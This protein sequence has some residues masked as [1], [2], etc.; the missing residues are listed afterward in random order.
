MPVATLTRPHFQRFLKAEELK[1]AQIVTGTLECREVNADN[2]E[3][4]L[5]ISSFRKDDYGTR[6]DPSGMDL[7][8]Y[9]RNPLVSFGHM[10]DGGIYRLPVARG[11]PDSITIDDD[12]RIHMR[13]R[14]TPEDVFEFG[15][16]VYKLVRN[17]F[18]NGVS[19]AA[20]PDPNATEVVREA[21]G[22]STLVFRKWKLYDASIVP[23]PSND[24]ALV[25]ARCKKFKV[26]KASYRELERLLDD[27][28]EVTQEEVND[29]AGELQ[30]TSP[31]E[32]GQQGTA[33]EGAALASPPPEAP[34]EQIQDVQA[35]LS[36]ARAL[37]LKITISGKVH[38]VSRSL[39]IPETEDQVKHREYFEENKDILGLYRKLLE[40]LYR[41]IGERASGQEKS[42][43]ERILSLILSP[44]SSSS[45]PV[46]TATVE[47]RQ[48]SASEAS[49]LVAK[50]ATG[51]ASQLEQDLHSGMPIRKLDARMKELIQGALK[52]SISFPR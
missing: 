18:L 8:Q 20:Q 27:E 11:I 33:P 13:A 10:R 25:A 15:F 35:E 34:P 38:E 4:E 23:L 31:E 2:L 29:V 7:S 42:D 5:I 47:T 6:F 22:T 37:H 41:R 43:V 28:N 44:L 46:R 3:V 12:G 36:P 49:T 39:D 1:D 19:I 51:I 50:L 26:R 9:K 45:P 21:D 16:Q 24:D 14:F 40:R 30:G 52:S 32:Q 17:G 48:V